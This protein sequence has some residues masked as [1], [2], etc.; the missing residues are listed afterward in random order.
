MAELDNKEYSLPEYT[1]GFLLAKDIT[2]TFRGIK[3][4]ATS[5]AV[6]QS[7]S[8]MLAGSYGPFSASSSSSFGGDSSNLRVS[9]RSDG[10][11]ME[12]PGAQVIG[13]YTS[14]MDRFPNQDPHEANR[15]Y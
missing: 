7:A 3:T 2:M 15:K 13:Y 5:H 14:V 4:S 8:G 10:L 1:T 6:H 9:S 12:I 11:H